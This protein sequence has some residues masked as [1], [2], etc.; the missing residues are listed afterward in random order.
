MQGKYHRLSNEDKQGAAVTNTEFPT[1]FLSSELF[2]IYMFTRRD[3]FLFVGMSIKELTWTIS[4]SLS[5]VLT[6][7]K[8]CA[9]FSAYIRFYFAVVL[10]GSH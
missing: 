6:P 1:L 2:Y 10:N 8:L 7:V 3:S 9:G 5:D 4:E